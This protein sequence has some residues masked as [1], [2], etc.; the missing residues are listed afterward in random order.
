MATGAGVGVAVGARCFDAES[1][2]AVRV[3]AGEDGAGLVGRHHRSSSEVPPR[4]WI[5]G[6][7]GMARMAVSFVDGSARAVELGEGGPEG[8]RPEIEEAAL[9][10]A[11]LVEVEV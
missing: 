3:R 4:M 7:F 9:I 2:P 10:R 8:G 5:S 1:A 6:A 11:D